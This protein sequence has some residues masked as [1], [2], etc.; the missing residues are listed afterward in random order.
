M[1]GSTPDILDIIL[2]VGLVTPEFLVLVAALVWAGVTRS[3]HPTRS[4]RVLMGLGLLLGVRV[5]SIIVFWVVIP[6]AVDHLM[7]SGSPA[8]FVQVF[9]GIALVTNVLGA[10]GLA[11]LVWGALSKEAAP[12]LAQRFD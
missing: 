8:L 4:R 9:S 6:R 1:S 12:D 3:E 7:Q 5:L 2:R 10:A 11:V